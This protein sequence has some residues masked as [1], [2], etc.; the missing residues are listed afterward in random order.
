MSMRWSDFT[1]G[2]V[3][4]L[5]VVP[6]CS[7][8][9]ALS[10]HGQLATPGAPPP[11]LDTGS[12]LPLLALHPLCLDECHRVSDLQ[13]ALDATP[14]SVRVM[15]QSQLPKGRFGVFHACF[16]VQAQHVVMPLPFVHITGPP[17]VQFEA[18]ENC[19][20]VISLWPAALSW[21]MAIPRCSL[22]ATFPCLGVYKHFL[23]RKRSAAILAPTLQQL[24]PRR[25]LRCPLETSRSQS[26]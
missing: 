16:R 11:V 20:V 1:V 12:L 22:R 19:E 17:T 15:D 3:N 5:S 25:P 18:A 23:L 2:I 4:G 9:L 26:S 21:V 7:V 8:W 10:Q 13:E 14:F 24:D 6:S